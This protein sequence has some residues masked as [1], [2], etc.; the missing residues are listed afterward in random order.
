MIAKLPMLVHVNHI[1]VPGGS[2]IGYGT[3]VDRASGQSVTFCGE[4]RAMR[5]L[6]EALV[7]GESGVE[8]EVE[9]WQLLRG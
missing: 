6:G 1:V 5:Q 9:D 2:S 3:G 7:A 4:H 8:A